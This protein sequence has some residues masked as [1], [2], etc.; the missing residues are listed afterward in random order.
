VGR[1][2]PGHPWLVVGAHLPQAM[3]PSVDSGEAA[4]AGLDVRG[5]AL[6]SLLAREFALLA[7]H[8]VEAGSAGEVLTRVAETAQ[9]LLPAA[10]AVS[11][12]MRLGDGTFHTPVCLHPVARELD[13]IQ[14]DAGEGP[15]V[16]AARMTGL[17]LAVSSDLTTSQAWPEFGAA[18]AARGFVAVVS[19][20]LAP[21]PRVPALGSLNVYTRRGHALGATDHD[22]ALLLATHAALALAHAQALSYAELQ[23]GRLFRA[24]HPR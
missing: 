2:P 15:C 13:R 23:H 11:V 24:T 6:P 21:D 16:D 8:L 4:A 1:A 19:C 3:S 5:D 9:R 20:A 22:V 10:D 12:T 17:G 14:Y 7:V 18:A